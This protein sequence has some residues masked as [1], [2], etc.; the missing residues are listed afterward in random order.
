[1]K[2]VILAGGKGT[3][4][5]PY[6]TV[7]PKPLLPVGGIPILETIIRQLHRD[8]YDE[9]VIACGYLASFIRIYFDE[10]PVSKMIRI[11]YHQEQAPLGTAGALGTIGLDADAILVMNGDLLTTLNFRALMGFHI[12][13]KAAMTVAVVTRTIRV[14]MGVLT[15]DGSQIIGYTEKPIHEYVGSAG[16]YIYSRKALS[17]I[18]PGEYLDVPTL[19]A[20]LIAAKER[21]VAYRSDSF[22]LDMGNRDDYERADQEFNARRSEFLPAGV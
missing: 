4:L 22:W 9:V 13:S 7:F 3:R 5:A 10:S 19:V 20:Q 14:E 15:L 12:E 17:L 2:A 18:K 16:I 6:T 21:V 11:S 1:M 8:G